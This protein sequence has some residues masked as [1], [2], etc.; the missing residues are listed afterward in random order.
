MADTHT[1]TNTH[2]DIRTG[3]ISRNQAHAS[4]RPVRAWFKNVISKL[5]SIAKNILLINTQQYIDILMHQYL[6]C[7]I[8]THIQ[9][10]GTTMYQ[11]ITLS[12]H[13]YPNSIVHSNIVMKVERLYNVFVIYK[14]TF[15]SLLC[16]YTF[17]ILYVISVFL[18][19]AY[20]LYNYSIFAA[21][22]VGES[23]PADGSFLT[24]EDSEL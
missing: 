4:H 2:T 9:S 20:R 18:S 19:V 3:T 16:S 10:I 14:L 22:S 21:T 24:R 23:P 15:S 7:S 11:C 12:S 5:L 8:N 17:G 6:I 1:Y 13:H